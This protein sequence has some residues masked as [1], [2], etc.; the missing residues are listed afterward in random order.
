MSE[1]TIRQSVPFD[2]EAILKIERANPSA[3]HWSAESY[4]DAWGAPESHRV[5]FVAE[6]SGEV[7][8]FIVAREIAGEWELENA[9]VAPESQRAGIGKALLEKLLDV[10]RLSQGRRIF[11]EVRAS[12][13]AA[14]KLYE[15][16]GFTLVGQRKN[17]YRNPP[18]D[19]FLYEKN[20][21]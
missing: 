17:Y 21:P 1:F 14:R 4:S 13:L 11:L 12:N 18:E 9:A 2:L 5:G 15:A 16:Q 8:G 19:A 7:L 6:R 10:V 20:L 3:A